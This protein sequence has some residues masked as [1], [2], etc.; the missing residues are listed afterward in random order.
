[1]DTFRTNVALLAAWL[2]VTPGCTPDDGDDDSAAT[3][4]DTDDGGPEVICNELVE[5]DDGP[6]FTDVTAGL[7]LGGDGL[8]IQGGLVATADLDGDRWPDLF[9]SKGTQNERDDPA[10]PS[11]AVRLLL[12]EEGTSFQD[13]TFSSGFTDTRDGQQG[14]TTQFAIFGDL[15]NDGDADAYAANFIGYDTVDTGDR[16]EVLLNQGDGTFVLGPENVFTDDPDYDAV[17]S[18]AMLDHDHDGALDLFVGH[19]YA[20]YGYLDTSGQDSLFVGD[21][22]GSFA[23]VT[24]EAGMET[25]ASSFLTHYQDGIN[26]RPTWGVTA[27]D[28]DGD[29]HTDLLADSYGRQFN[30]L[31]HANGDGTY[32]DIGRDVGFASDDN[33]DYTDNYYYGTEYWSSWDEYPFRNGGNS[34]KAICGDLDNDGDLDLLQI[35]LRHEWTG[36]SSDMTELL[37]NEGVGEGGTFDRPGREATGLTREHDVPMTEMWNEGDLGGALFDFDND[38]QL[39]A[40]VASSD[41]PYT[42][43]LSWHQQDDGTF[44]D[45]SVASGLRLDR[46]HGVSVLDYD[47]D[48]DYDVVLGTSRMRWEDDDD[49]SDPGAA[50]M[51]LFRNDVGQAG[52]RLMIDLEGDGTANRDALGARIVARAGDDLFVREVIGG[53]GIQG[54]QNDPLQIIGTGEHCTLDSVEIRW[55]DASGTVSTFENVRANYVLRIHQTDG[56][57][58]LSMEEYLAGP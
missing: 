50:Y 11:Y 1:M 23:D 53:H 56:L 41:Y 44:R 17:V 30:M 34:A 4:D 10:D 27:C 48:G 33:E 8:D 13:V 29:G 35:E 22:A 9:L 3:D 46:A 6:W 37:Y 49:P 54:Q 40:L 31:W 55:P 19:H 47:R 38:G 32:T 21:G 18:A 26:H 43:S 28:I 51:Y 16:S 7:G 36:Q 57:E 5:L 20:R 12:N 39:D 52:N 2:L 24:V 14:R 42:W 58:Y 15:D 25:V 45:V